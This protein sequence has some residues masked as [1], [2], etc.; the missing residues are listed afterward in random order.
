MH[1]IRITCGAC[2]RQL[3][4]AVDSA[5]QNIKCPICEA[6]IEIRAFPALLRAPAAEAP[7][8]V[9]VDG[10]STC[11]HHVQN[12]AAVACDHCGKFLCTL[13]DIAVDDQHLCPQC[14][15][16]RQSGADGAPRGRVVRYD[17]VALSLAI[18]PILM[19]P[20]TVITAPITLYIV[21]R[22]WSVPGP[23][24]G[25]SRKIVLVC[26]GLF[27]LLELLA[28]AG[29]IVALTLDVEP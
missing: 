13:C 1:P 26:A 15:E 17:Q 20:L 3:S 12:K 4:I 6:L 21:V 29:V 24:S 28:W 11:F 14:F 27:A 7:Q 23:R 10:E 18:L 9:L 22:Y 19:F 2:K 5:Q 16:R 25:Y 8:R